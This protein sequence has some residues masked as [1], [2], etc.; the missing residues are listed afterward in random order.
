MNNK[1]INE[2][3]VIKER[4]NRTKTEDVTKTKGHDF[5][6]YYLKEEL[7]MGL[8]KKGFYKPSPVQEE[9]IPLALAGNNLITRAKNG[10][11]KTGAYVIPILEK[12]DISKSHI[13]AV[14]LIPT[15]ELALQVSS[16][17]K[18]VGVFLKVECM[19]STGGTSFKEDVLRLDNKVHI[20]VGTP[21]RIYD[22]LKKKIAR[23]DQCE[24][25]VLD[26]AD[27]L[28]SLDFMPI[29]EKIIS[30]FPVNKQLMLFSATFPQTVKH[31]KDKYI[32]QATVVNLMQ[33]LTLK[34]VTQYYV[35]LEDKQK[36]VC[37]NVLFSKLNL[38]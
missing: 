15:R 10:T 2:E 18:E 23:I 29:V 1:N 28:L 11:G 34:G 33:E 9:C 21:G 36:V 13:Q 38:Q 14:I 30:F 6:D 3:K 8:V 17:I 26:E 25:L 20:L 12:I 22:L 4:E 19:I 16:F 37:L 32:P 35:Y 7:M 24:M 5:E 31:F 27:K